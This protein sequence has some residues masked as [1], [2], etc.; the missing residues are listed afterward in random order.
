MS[1]VGNPGR[2]PPPAGSPII[3]GGFFRSG[4]SLFRR[5][6]DSHSRI[7]CPPE[8]KFFRD[9]YGDYHEAPD[10]HARFFTTVRAIGLSEDELL[11]IF[12]SAYVTSRERAAAKLGKKRWADKNPENVLYLE[13]WAR[14]LR[15]GFYFIDV[16]RHPLDVLA[17]V[18]EAQFNRTV[19]PDLT[20]QVELFRRYARAGLDYTAEHPERSFVVRY[21][22]LVERP[23]ETVAAVME[24]LGEEFEPDMIRGAF[25]AGRQRGLED[26]KIEHTTAVHR[27]S[28][29]RWKR[30]LPADDARAA[31]DCLG[32]IME[33][34]GYRA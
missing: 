28:L 4:T 24:F 3:I 16:V 12:G 5:I 31:L 6:L 9:F 8:V 11:T 1:G 2:T 21:E 7:H 17:S 26:P 22:S 30:D 14:L 20:S 15:D 29:G 25:A 10:R 27:E 18:M 19:P 33:E 13:Q 34:M 23:E 32:G